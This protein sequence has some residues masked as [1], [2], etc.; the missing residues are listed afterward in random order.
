MLISKHLK[1]WSCTH[2]INSLIRK[3]RALGLA[4]EQEIAEQSCDHGG[5]VFIYS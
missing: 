1:L 5:T 4:K 3:I 2:K